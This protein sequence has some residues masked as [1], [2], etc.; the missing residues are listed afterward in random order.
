MKK[1]LCFIILGFWIVPVF[2]QDVDTTWV[3]RFDGVGGPDYVHALAVDNADNVYVTGAIG[4]GPTP[5]YGT[6]KYDL[7]GTQQ[8]VRAY[9]NPGTDVAVAI[10]LDGYGNVCVTGYANIGGSLDYVTIKYDPD[11][12]QL[13]LIPFN[14]GFT[15]MAQDVA[16]DAAGNVYVTGFAFNP[17]NNN[18]NYLTQK[19]FPGGGVAWTQEFNGA[20]NGDDTASVIAVDNSGN[21]FVAGQSKVMQNPSTRVIGLVKYDPDGN[22]LWPVYFGSPPGSNSDYPYDMTT[23]AAGYVYVT[24]RMGSG[25]NYFTTK[26]ASDGTAQW[27]KTYNGP[28]NSNDE[29]KAL[30]VDADGNVYVT[31]YS[32]GSGTNEDYATIKYRANGDTAWVR[33]YDGPESNHDYATA[34]AIDN[35]GNVYVTG[36]SYTSSTGWDY[37]TVKYDSSGNQMWVKRYNGPAGIN[38]VAVSIAVNNF[39][40]VYVSGYSEGAG[41][42]Y[43]YAT[44]KYWQNNPP[45]AF[46]LLSPEEDVSIPPGVIDFDWEDAI[47]SD[48]WDTVRYDLYVSTSPVFHPDSTTIYDSLLT[49]EHSDDFGLGTYYWKVKAYDNHAEIWSNQTWS[50][51]VV[52]QLFGPPSNYG[53]GSNPLSVFCA[54]LDGDGD[55]DMA[56]A[57]LESQ[58]VSILKNNGDGTFAA[59]ENYS[60]A[61]HP[62]SVFCADLDGDGDLD[63]AVSCEFAGIFIFR[64]NGDGA[65]VNAG[66][67]TAGTSIRYLFCADLDEDDDLDL[68]VSDA[69]GDRISVLKNNGN[70][71]FASALYYEV[72]DEPVSPFCA[73]LDGDGD[74]DLAVT[75]AYSDNVSVLKNSGTGTFETKVDY[76]VIDGPHSV[77][78]IDLDMDGDLDLAVTNGYE[79]SGDSISVLINNGDGTFA[80]ATNYKVGPRAFYLFSS[81]IDGDADF[82]LAVANSW[83]NNVSILGNNGDGTF[84]TAVNYET[85]SGPMYPFCADLD[86]DGDFDLAVTIGSSGNV[87][88]ILENLT[89]VPA[90]QAPHPFP[91]L[92]PEDGS[93]VPQVLTLDWRTPYD[94]NFGDQ[95]R[96]DL[97]ISTSPSFDPDSTIRYSGLVISRDSVTLGT[98]TYYWKVKAYDNWGAEVWSTQTWSF[99]TA[100]SS[101]LVGYWK[102]DEGSGTTAYDS[103]G[104]GNHGTLVN[105]TVWTSGIM[106][107]ALEF[108][109]TNQY[110]SYPTLYSSSPSAVTVCAWIKSSLQKSEM[111]IYH[112]DNGEFALAAGDV[113]DREMNFGIKLTD[114]SWYSIYSSEITPN[115]WHHIAGTWSKGEQ[116]II[117]IDGELD[118]AMSVPDY[119]LCDASGYLPSIGAYNRGEDRL[120]EGII[121]HVKI[122]RIALTPEEIKTEFEAGFIRG[123][124]TGDGVIDAGDVVYLIN[125]LYRGGPAPTPLASGDTTCDGNVDAG[126]V[127]YLINYLYRS[128]PAPSC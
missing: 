121:D 29:A 115:V 63:L 92:S 30:A 85:P 12:N 108:N 125:Y 70:A 43:D 31:G 44:I 11:G 126:D 87:V 106:G 32:M 3:R 123:D 13:W 20:A 114:G 58:N 50:F 60:V 23:D 40:N 101:G 95:M 105:E 8:W 102:F 103:S 107:S 52:P 112:G 84:A 67:Y 22:Q 120:F 2:A 98:D 71:T 10:A 24:G 109:G 54:D 93:W 34:I 61:N 6:I 104:Y 96:Y 74:L 79:D 64:N 94:P 88:S 89:E 81:D 9:S 124:V 16:A 118:S 72:G 42:N 69:W 7:N 62:I 119:Y 46:S 51:N 76:P 39:G 17:M 55:L 83:S 41:T 5:D 82:D 75:N 38:D 73:D 15:E 97:Y 57:N 56:V 18:I 86:G 77:F 4:T 28:G 99:T 127:V 59:A 48:P 47:D 122:Y 111:I 49:S 78:C 21:V 45:N 65:F 116:L 33:R 26:Y 91:L 117:Y 100:S 80:N 68:I 128:G 27:L 113:I 53:V 14:R 1:L 90:N 110:V 35:L 19:Y 37:A 66:S 25:I 36:Q